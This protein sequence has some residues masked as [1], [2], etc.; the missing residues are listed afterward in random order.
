MLVDAMYSFDVMLFAG[1]TYLIWASWMGRLPVVKHLLELKANI[2]AKDNDGMLL[3]S[4]SVGFCL[5]CMY[6]LS[7]V[8]GCDV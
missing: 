6:L 1:R 7:H 2:E 5:V 8:S 3:D 4:A